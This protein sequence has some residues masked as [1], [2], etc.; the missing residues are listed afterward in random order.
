MSLDP[1]FKKHLHSLMVE[2]YEKTVDATE[3][4]KRELLFGARA[5]H[6]AAA[7]PIAYKDAALYAMEFRIGRTIER[8]IEAIAISGCPIGTAFET[9]MIKEFWSL[10]AGPNQLQFPPAVRGQHAQ[11]VQGSYARERQRLAA[12]LVR[13]GTNRL[14]E[15]KMKTR[16]AER[17]SRTS[18][19]TI[20][21]TFNGPVGNAFI[22]SS[23]IQ[24]TNNLTITAQTIKDIDEISA[25]NSELQAAAL[26]LRNAHAQ[27]TGT[28]ETLQ[29]WATLALAVGGV[30]DKIHQYY[31]RI[32]VLIDQLKNVAL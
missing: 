20:N 14:R 16:Q 4:H 9:A 8:Y 10:T 3:Q 19:S 13:E 28:V 15:L 22:N 17:S 18:D 1:E 5:T 21:N 11:A 2:V 25:G 24:T 27:S 29:K 30:A 7:T 32:A 6:N 31:P 23:V 12:R 26:E